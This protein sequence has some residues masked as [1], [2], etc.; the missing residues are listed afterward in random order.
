VISGLQSLDE[1]AAAAA[2]TDAVD[3]VSDADDEF[4]G[5][6]QEIDSSTLTVA[7]HCYHSLPA[8]Q[9]SDDVEVCFSSRLSLSLSL[10]LSA[11]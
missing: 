6:V 4:S 7:F 1:A 3:W 8:A 11:V 5:S 2:E 9:W 10:S